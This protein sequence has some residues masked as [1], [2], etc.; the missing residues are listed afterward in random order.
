MWD[1]I[2]VEF[3]FVNIFLV[4]EGVGIFLNKNIKCWNFFG[5]IYLKFY[6][7]SLY[8]ECYYLEGWSKVF[9]VVLL[10]IILDIKGLNF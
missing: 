1:K 10:C 3:K 5:Y 2:F 4:C 7:E 8:L 6:F 9:R